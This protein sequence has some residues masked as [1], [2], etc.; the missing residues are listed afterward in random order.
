MIVGNSEE[1]LKLMQMVKKVALNKTTVLIGGESGTGKQLI[2]RAIHNMSERNDKPLIQV[3]CTTLSEQL[4]ESDLFG[5]ERGA[6]TGAHQM[7]KGRVELAH[8]GTLF[9][10]E[11]GDLSPKIQAKLLHFLEQGEFE[12][13]GG[14]R[15]MQVNARVI[16]A[17]NKNLE[18]EV[19]ENRFRE[20]LY[21][22]LN[23]VKLTL[24]PLRKRIK[25]IPL[26]LDH[27]LKKFSLE[28]NKKVPRMNNSALQKLRNYNWPGN[29]REFENTIERV[30][31]LASDNVI[32]EDLLPDSI[33]SRCEEIIDA[34]L[35]L[36][37]AILKFKRQFIRKTMDLT[38]NNQTKA[39]EILN[40][41]R[42]Y[43]SRLIK[44]MNLKEN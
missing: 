27:F 35:Q 19:K 42:T 29:I 33:T 30:V 2:A 31:V 3:N 11:I 17:T 39:A 21:Y 12:R 34:G 5:H 25:D 8:K 18:Q 6:F 1:M 20:D 22:R 32:T 28:L 14:M 13:V 16:A 44:E 9:L 41:Q 10:D 43:L 23:V 7:K 24:P 4:L 37:E 26:L 15:S 40:I 36:D 38:N